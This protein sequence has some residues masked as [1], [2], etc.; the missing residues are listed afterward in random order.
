MVKDSELFTHLFLCQTRCNVDVCSHAN[1]KTQDKKPTDQGCAFDHLCQVAKLSGATRADVFLQPTTHLRT[2]LRSLRQ[3]R[4]QLR[5]FQQIKAVERL[6]ESRLSL[7]C[8]F[9]VRCAMTKKGY[10][11]RILGRIQTSR[12]NSFREHFDFQENT[13]FKRLL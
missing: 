9:L 11:R 8:P 7:F 5:T 12:E 13:F 2:Q 1:A 10:G 3:S 6:R 4:I